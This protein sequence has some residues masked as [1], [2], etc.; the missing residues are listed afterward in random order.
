MR[1]VIYLFVLLFFLESIRFEQAVRKY[2]LPIRVL[3]LNIDESA[4]IGMVNITGQ[5]LA[6]L[7]GFEELYLKCNNIHEGMTIAT[8]ATMATIATIATIATMA[9]IATIATYFKALQYQQI[10]FF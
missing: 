8:I 1:F 7:E 10:S 9:T 6:I 3:V 2:T 5:E 4:P